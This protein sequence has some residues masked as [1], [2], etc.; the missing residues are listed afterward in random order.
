MTR[1]KSP[2]DLV[3][4]YYRNPRPDVHPFIP[5]EAG[6][7]L[8]IGCGAGAFGE[9][10]TQQGI[11]VSGIELHPMVA[12]F[13]RERLS[14]V[15]VGDAL[16]KI[17]ELPDASFDL[18]TACDVLEHLPYPGQVLREAIRV[19]R[20]GGRVVASLPNI[21]YWD[22]FRRILW[23]GDFPQEDHGIFD[24]THL[25]WFTQKSIPRFCAENG[26][27]ALT[28]QGV[29]P[30]PS[31]EFADWRRKHGEAFEDCRWL[32]FVIVARPVGPR[33]S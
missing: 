26:F 33:T 20:P 17:R 3:K 7:V 31:R 12:K 1:E 19:L 4:P 21:R 23:E 10:M 22:A 27:E 8:D 14:R 16:E 28:V 6:T 29:N 9:W 18:V 32:Q 2:L 24:R 5:R 30:T 11:E 15:L 25:R 13:A